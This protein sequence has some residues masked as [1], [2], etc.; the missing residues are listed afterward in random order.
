MMNPPVYLLRSAG[1]TGTGFP[2]A[3]SSGGSSAEAM[4]TVAAHAIAVHP[5]SA[6]SK[7]L[8]FIAVLSRRCERAGVA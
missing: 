7:S 6:S 2:V 4:N 5:I 3:A 8:D 1:D